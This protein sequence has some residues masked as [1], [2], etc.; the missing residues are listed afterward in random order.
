VLL[1]D[2]VWPAVSFLKGAFAG[3]DP[4]TDCPA[5][6]V[7][8]SLVRSVDLDDFDLDFAKVPLLRE[9]IEG[10]SIWVALAWRKVTLS[11]IC[12]AALA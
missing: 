6:F 3:F 1:E 9:G 4:F 8:L 7:P 12:S 11:C 2:P 5:F 10:R